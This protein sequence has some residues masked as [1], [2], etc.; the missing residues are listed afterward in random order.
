[1][2]LPQITLHG[3]V[4]TSL[5]VSLLIAVFLP[6]RPFLRRVIGSEWL[7]VLWLALLIRLLAPWPLES[8]WSV[9]NRW[10]GTGAP[11]VT[12]EPLK[13][14]VSFPKDADAKDPHTAT[15]AAALPVVAAAAMDSHTDLPTIANRVWL[16][17]AALSLGILALRWFQT[18]RLAS[19]T[20]PA[21]DDRLRKLFDSIPQ[22]LRRDTRLRM[23]NA[24]PVPTLAGVF[25]PQIWMPLVWP[26]Q[27]TDDEL[28]NVL[29]HELG[30]A[31][32]RD[33]LVQWVFA[34][35]QCIHWFNPL[36]WLAARAARFDREMACDAWVLA[37]SAAGNTDYGSA[38]VKAVQLLRT[39]L[40]VNPVS[41]AMASNRHDL[42]ARIS[43]IVAFQRLP[44]WRGAF[45]VAAMITMLATVTT[46]CKKAAETPSAT[47][48]PAAVQSSTPAPKAAAAGEQPVIK[49]E[50]KFVEIDEE[51][52]RKLCGE[53]PAFKAYNS[54]LPELAQEKVP[55]G[56]ITDLLTTPDK[57]AWE[58]SENFNSLSTLT[59][60][61][62]AAM[63]ESLNHT[64]DALL[65]SAPS[66]V[67]KDKQRTKVDMFIEFPYPSEFVKNKNPMPIETKN[68]AGET[69]KVI[70]P[71]FSP[72][73]FT[74]KNVGVSLEAVP[75]LN[76][77]D[78]IRLALTPTLT[79]FLGFLTDEDGVKK[80]LAFDLHD[81]LDYFN[82][83]VFSTSTS[84]ITTTIRPG[85]TA[86]L[87]GVH[88]DYKADK[89]RQAQI[90][91]NLTMQQ[92][93]ENPPETIRHVELVFVTAK[94]EKLPPP[95]APETSGPPAAPGAAFPNLAGVDGDVVAVNTGS[96]FAVINI[97]SHQGAVQNA[98]ALVQR[99]D[100]MVAIL[101]I[102]QI[103]PDASVA[104]V[105]LGTET[106]GVRPMQGDKVVLTGSTIPDGIP[107]PG[108]EGFVT[109]PY[110]PEKGMIDLRGYERETQVK[111]PYTGKIFL[112][113]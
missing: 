98:E 10:P 67:T 59:N 91:A 19:R 7:C 17:G 3:L 74:T 81:S 99:G 29:L 108:K 44:A 69:I 61:E 41:I 43:G 65:Q 51:T 85:E 18:R 77:D 52:W 54:K 93:E 35:A 48:T 39:P 66:V 20:L 96:H 75:E 90:G 36:V 80:T 94:T 14:K 106:A 79:S 13:I 26:A 56:K 57:G 16:A 4:T 100:Q 87:A 27:F 97:G 53:D 2:I 72:T 22:E 12:A 102:D 34:I 40:R 25:R 55:Y 24:L 83:P 103:E 95:T 110:A 86:L 89:I 9:F 45:G 58:V 111:D 21:T 70:L 15:P 5:L 78:T 30:H 105:V 50:M 42:R 6:L 49:L 104:G 112:V 88:L 101:R 46:S 23:T 71:R 107:V 109:S 64:R 11:V 113:P 73:A 76:K 62:V 32:R 1:M 92:P 37:R 38:L 68:A 31:R 60:T 28:R 84:K 82:R 63:L 8:R 33:L 47:G